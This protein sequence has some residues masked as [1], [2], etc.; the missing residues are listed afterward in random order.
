[1]FLV[2]IILPQIRFHE[3]R[4]TLAVDLPQGTKCTRP[5]QG[6]FHGIGTMVEI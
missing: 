4:S 3:R 5:P 6:V 2:P 1:M